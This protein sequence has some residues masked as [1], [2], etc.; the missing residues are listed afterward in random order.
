MPE[1]RAGRFT[2]CGERAG[3]RAPGVHPPLVMGIAHA[4]RP[5][6]PAAVRDTAG[7]AAEYRVTGIERQDTS[8]ELRAHCG[9]QFLQEAGRRP[10]LPG[11]RGTP[12]A[13]IAHRPSSASLKTAAV[14]LTVTPPQTPQARR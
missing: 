14:T 7:I 1:P 12:A 6:R 3:V 11:P 9:H 10:A 4:D 5:C 8:P 2:R 13:G